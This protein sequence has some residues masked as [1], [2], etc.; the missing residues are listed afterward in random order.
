M[1]VQVV[2][3]AQIMCSFRV[4]PSVLTVRPLGRRSSGLWPRAHSASAP[5][6]VWSRS[7][8]PDRWP[9]WPPESGAQPAGTASPAPEGLH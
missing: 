4:A 7:W 2:D 9:P 6:V 8:C 1:A 3:G 5:G